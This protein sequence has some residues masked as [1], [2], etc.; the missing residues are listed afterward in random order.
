M[1]TNLIKDL[2]SGKYY[3]VDVNREAFKGREEYTKQ[4]ERKSD[5]F[6]LKLKNNL[7]LGNEAKIIFSE[8]L[9][10]SNNK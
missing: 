3:R 4:G 5:M 7:F 8:Y 1:A 2:K 6:V 9:M 10:P